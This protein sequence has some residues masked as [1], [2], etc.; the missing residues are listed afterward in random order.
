MSVLWPAVMDMQQREGCRGMWVMWM[1][2]GCNM[3]WGFCHIHTRVLSIAS[4]AMSTTFTC[5]LTCFT[6]LTIGCLRLQS[7]GVTGHHACPVQ[8]GVDGLADGVAAV[9]Q[10]DICSTNRA[11]RAVTVQRWCVQVSTSAVRG[12]AYGSTTAP[13]QRQLDR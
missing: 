12:L 4:T 7:A 9:R 13:V 1:P 3:L 11:V 5:Y 2:C 8:Q 6:C 10:L